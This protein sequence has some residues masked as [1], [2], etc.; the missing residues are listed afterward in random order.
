MNQEKAIFFYQENNG[1]TMLKHIKAD[2]QLSVAKKKDIDNRKL[3]LDYATDLTNKPDE[4]TIAMSNNNEQWLSDW[5]R[6][7]IWN[8]D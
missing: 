1:L 5:S 7:L 4:S 2:K 8:K 3:I 6:L